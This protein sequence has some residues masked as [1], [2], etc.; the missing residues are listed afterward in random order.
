MIVA[1]TKSLCWTPDERRRVVDWEAVGL[2][3]V[4]AVV[5]SSKGA[6]RSPDLVTSCDI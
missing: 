5:V 3:P 6:T 1:C 4:A 2:R